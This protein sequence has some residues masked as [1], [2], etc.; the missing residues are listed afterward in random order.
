[1]DSLFKGGITK[2]E[3]DWLVLVY[4]TPSPYNSSCLVSHDDVQYH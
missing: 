1:M 3:R 2:M 4:E